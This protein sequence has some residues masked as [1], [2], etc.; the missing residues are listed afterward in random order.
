MQSNLIFD[1]LVQRRNISFPYEEPKHAEMFWTCNSNH[2]V[3]RRQE[4]KK[5]ELKSY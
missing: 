1:N 2:D 3:L 4:D 5:A